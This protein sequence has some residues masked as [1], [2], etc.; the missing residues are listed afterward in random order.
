MLRQDGSS[1]REVVLELS[2]LIDLWT[3]DS[4]QSIAEYGLILALIVVFIL[5]SFKLMVYA[6][7]SGIRPIAE[8]IRTGN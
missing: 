2:G 7:P 8:Q 3:N 1:K 4:A 5:V 6:I